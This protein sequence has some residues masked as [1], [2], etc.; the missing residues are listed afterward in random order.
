MGK[1]MSNLV[2]M[3]PARIQIAYTPTT[4]R[5][6]TAVLL[7]MTHRVSVLQYVDGTHAVEVDHLRELQFPKQRFDKPVQI[8]IFMYGVMR[9]PP[10][11]QQQPDNPLVPLRDLPTDI[12]FPGL[13]PQHQVPLETRRLVARLHLNLGH[14]SPQ[15]L[16]RMVAYHGG[17]PPSVNMCIE[18]M[19]CATCERLKPPQHPRPAAVAK[20]NVGQFADEV[21]GDFVYIRTL[22]GENVAVLGLLDRATGPSSCCMPI[23][24][25][26]RRL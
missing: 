18:H 5:L 10:Q 19:R 21:Q 15:E 16:T 8:A 22:H 11:P 2:R 24:G 17:A 9:Q 20:M 13:S 12:T 23:Q 26:Q 7:D 4:R 25:L 6:P 14:P 1:E 3:D